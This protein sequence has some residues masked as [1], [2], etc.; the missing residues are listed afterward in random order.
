MVLSKLVIASGSRDSILSVD[1][2]NRN[3]TLLGRAKRGR[4]VPGHA[5]YCI[6]RNDR[7][8]WECRRVQCRM[9]VVQSYGKAVCRLR[10]IGA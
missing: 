6:R 5:V 7:V 3:H 4:V 9:V 1:F 10:P 2:Q 8:S